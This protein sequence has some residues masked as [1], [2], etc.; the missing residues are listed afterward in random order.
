MTITSI[1]PDEPPIEKI[2]DKCRHKMT[3]L[4]VGK[5]QFMLFM[6]K[7]KKELKLRRN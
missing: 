3:P 1:N 7:C 4:I 2:V 6:L 5:I